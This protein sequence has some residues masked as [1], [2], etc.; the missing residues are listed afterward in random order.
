[1]NPLNRRSIAIVEIFLIVVGLVFLVFGIL[2]TE[3]YGISLEK[4]LPDW[5]G[6]R[7]DSVLLLIVG[8]CLVL[9]LGI[10]FLL[11]A[12][13]LPDQSKKRTKKMIR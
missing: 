12:Y 6:L 11:W 3:T 1:M 7:P 2:N 8:S 13:R 9:T 10:I 5:W 4:E